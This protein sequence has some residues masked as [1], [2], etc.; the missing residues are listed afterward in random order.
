M[1]VQNKGKYVRHAAGVMLVPG[2]NQLA[3]TDWK[4]FSAH[5]LIK[6]LVED[7]EIVAH[8]SAKTTKDLNANEAIELVKDTFSLSLLEEWKA[9]EKRSTV[10]A[11]ITEQS[12]LI[13]NGSGEETE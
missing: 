10:L 5:P 1:L 4:K 6:D 3:P 9:T 11:A 7:E 13:V 8:E 2:A 12:N